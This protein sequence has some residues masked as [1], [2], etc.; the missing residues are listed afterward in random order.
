MSLTQRDVFK[1]IKIRRI[2]AGLPEFAE[3]G[4]KNFITAVKE[5]NEAKIS[6]GTQKKIQNIPK[7]PKHTCRSC[8]IIMGWPEDLRLG[9]H[10]ESK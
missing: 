6:Y 9:S 2:N 10:V 4:K 5:I 8:T 3:K 7:E 1:T